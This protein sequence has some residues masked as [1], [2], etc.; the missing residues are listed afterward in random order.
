LKLLGSISEYYPEEN[1]TFENKKSAL[2]KIVIFDRN[3][4]RGMCCQS[5]GTD[6]YQMLRQHACTSWK[7]AVVA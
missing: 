4:L 7:K 5:D 6:F 3:N 2:L 1:T